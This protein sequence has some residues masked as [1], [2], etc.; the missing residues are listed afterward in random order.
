MN[1]LTFAQ[2]LCN[3]LELSYQKDEIRMFKEYSNEYTNPDGWRYHAAEYQRI[4]R[5]EHNF[6][7]KP[8]LDDS[9]SDILVRCET[10]WNG[11]P[12]ILAR[13]D[14]ETGAVYAPGAAEPSYNLLDE[15]SRRELF[16]RAHY[17][18]RYL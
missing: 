13:I 5:D 17:S 9:G 14:K 16:H 18:K 3:K 8:Y 2:T 10:P 1:V 7:Y 12:S 4:L 15:P 6:A 11:M